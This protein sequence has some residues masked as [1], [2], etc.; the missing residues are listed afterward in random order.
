L[1]LCNI[2]LFQV[3]GVEGL[4]SCLWSGVVL[5]WTVLQLNIVLCSAGLGE[6]VGTK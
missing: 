6:V 2:V 1:V 4:A 3:V 5:D